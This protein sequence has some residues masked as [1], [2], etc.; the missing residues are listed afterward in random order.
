[1]KALLGRSWEVLVS[2]SCK[3]LSSSSNDHLVSWHEDLRQH[4]LQPIVRTS[5]GDPGQVF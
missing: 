4:L 3:V 5:C 2:R 1:M